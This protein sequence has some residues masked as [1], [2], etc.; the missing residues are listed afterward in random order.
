MKHDKQYSFEEVLSKLM[1]YCSYQERSSLEIKQKAISLGAGSNEIIKLI[2]LL[3]EENFYNERRFVESYVRGKLRIKRWGKYKIIEG[4]RAKGISTNT[5]EESLAVVPDESYLRN[6][7]YL[8]DKRIVSENLKREEVAK[9][10]RY[11][12]SKGYEASLIR[13]IFEKK[14]WMS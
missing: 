4:L 3:E 7:R 10:Y 13:I 1:K 11:F 2:E 14:G 9:H 5:I 12:L 6:L 8:V